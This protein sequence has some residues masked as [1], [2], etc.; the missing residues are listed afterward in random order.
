MCRCCSCTRANIRW[1]PHLK[2]PITRTSWQRGA[3]D[4]AVGCCCSLPSPVRRDCCILFVSH[5]AF[6][7]YS[8]FFRN[9]CEFLLRSGTK[10]IVVVNRSGSSTSGQRQFVAVHFDRFVHYIDCMD[11]STSLAGRQH[12]SGGRVTVFLLCSRHCAIRTRSL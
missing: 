1:R 4:S 3:S 2:R 8:F 11:I 9:E 10:P 7:I 12:D 6:Y 5:R